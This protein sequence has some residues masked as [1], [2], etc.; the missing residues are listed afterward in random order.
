MA[1]NGETE[2]SCLSAFLAEL[3]IFAVED[4]LTGVLGTLTKP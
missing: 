3:A 1:A 4:E 2:E